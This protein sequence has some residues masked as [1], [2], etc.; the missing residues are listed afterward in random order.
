M[1]SEGE[2]TEIDNAS[3]PMVRKYK[4]L[5][6]RLNLSRLAFYFVF[7]FFT[8]WILNAKF[9]KQKKMIKFTLNTT[10]IW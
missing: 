2:N 7:F 3:C 1:D 5:G 8:V 9:Q 4:S 6:D 10:V